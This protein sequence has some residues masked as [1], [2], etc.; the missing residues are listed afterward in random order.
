[1]LLKYPK[2]ECHG[3]GGADLLTRSR[4]DHCCGN[5]CCRYLIPLLELSH[6]RRRRRHRMS[7]S[8]ILLAARRD[9]YDS[10]LRDR[11]VTW[12][13]RDLLTA[14]VTLAHI[15]WVLCCLPI[16]REPRGR[17]AR[18]TVAIGHRRAVGTIVAKDSVAR[19]RYGYDSGRRLGW[20]MA[21]LPSCR[22]MLFRKL[23]AA[24]LCSKRTKAERNFIFLLNE[25]A[26][27]HYK[28]SV[29][30]TWHQF[31]QPKKSMSSKNF[32]SMKS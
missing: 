18:A 25:F 26:F 32:V 3:R 10:R 14:G 8:S 17:S 29:D 23:A 22:R 15:M 20:P 19:P 6:C 21:R 5:H 24:K 9:R 28:M 13:S 30:F 27:Y 12:W 1:M 4:A 31:D 16:C 2:K 7:Q 11:A